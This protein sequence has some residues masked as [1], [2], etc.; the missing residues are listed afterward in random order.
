MYLTI[1]IVSIIVA[2]SVPWAGLPNPW[3]P[4][5]YSILRW[6]L[7]VVLVVML[8]FIWLKA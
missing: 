1:I 4:N 7:S 3:A 2:L 6:A 5:G 8:C